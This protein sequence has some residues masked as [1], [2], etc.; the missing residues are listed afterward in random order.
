MIRQALEH[1][2]EQPDLF[3]G[4]IHRAAQKQIGDAAQRLDPARD[5]AVRQRGLQLIEQVCGN[6]G[7]F[8]TQGF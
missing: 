8:R 4:I 6:G 7:G 5:R 1:V 3:V 2:V